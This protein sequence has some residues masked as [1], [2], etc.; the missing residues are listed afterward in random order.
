[1]KQ[2]TRKAIVISFNCASRVNLPDSAAQGSQKTSKSRLS[3]LREQSAKKFREAI[4]IEVCDE[5]W[6]VKSNG[7]VVGYF[8][9][10]FVAVDFA[11][12]LASGGSR[13]VLY[14]EGSVVHLLRPVNHDYLP[15]S[16][17]EDVS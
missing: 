4:I 11:R 17:L 3:A 15:C 14:V 8:R 12:E 9:H 5:F 10:Q 16:T 7:K 6:R 2:P 1:M 13:P